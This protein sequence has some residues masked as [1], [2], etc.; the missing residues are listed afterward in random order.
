MFEWILISIHVRMEVSLPLGECVY[1]CCECVLSY[2]NHKRPKDERNR[3]AECGE[4]GESG[5]ACKA[6]NRNSVSFVDKM[7]VNHRTNMARDGA[8]EKEKTD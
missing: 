4:R 5:S 2:T 8:S 7:K 1:A 6:A 3:R